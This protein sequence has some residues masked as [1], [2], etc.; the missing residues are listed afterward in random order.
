M[1][2]MLLNALSMHTYTENGATAHNTSGAGALLDLF[3]MCGSLRSRLYVIDQK[4]RSA[5]E[6]NPL[7]ATKLA[8]FTRDI[9]GGLGERDAARAMFRI[10]AKEHPEVMRKNLHLLAEYGRY[11]DLV[12]LV[13][14][15][16]KEDVI[17]LIRDQLAEDTENMQKGESVSLLAKW[18]PSINTSSYK[19]RKKA[20]QLSMLLNMSARE[21]RKVLSSL[22]AYLNVT[23]VRMSE[24]N[25]DCIRYE[26][27]PSRAMNLY[28]FAF[29]RN[30]ESRF[31]QYIQAVQNGEA[32]ISAAAV[33][34]YDIAEKYTDQMLRMDFYED[35]DEDPVLEAQWKALPN[36]IESENN[37]LI[38]VDVSGSM[39]GRPIA[40]S[41]GLGIYFAE[42]NKGAFR[43]TFM[44][45]SAKP[46]LIKISRNSLAEKIH[47]V[48]SS[49]VGYN[50]DLEAAF[51]RVLITAKT[52]HIPQSEMPES[53]IVISD[54]EIDMLCDQTNW[55]FMEEM[56]E[57]FEEVG[58]QL[59]NLVLWNVASRND[60]FHASGLAENVQFCS[61]SSPAVFKSLIKSVGMTPYEYMLSVLEDPRYDPVRI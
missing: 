37:F 5:Y 30:D 27:V 31:T 52:N 23:E 48:F 16:V 12:S 50:T 44:T 42:R 53:I 49:G 14:T 18:M 58:Y 29:K 38:M 55:T 32:S 9:R 35:L 24:K 28:R 15:P 60:I 3:S 8:F 43:N 26:A 2:N 34:P 57:R 13:N 6:E 51:E 36:Y 46:E 7:L 56:K 4:F 47:S 33:F 45:F 54:G 21:Y 40:T 20:E 59:P 1:T 11:D 25:Y 61:G 19:A 41:V 10:L 22:R 17:A 39:W